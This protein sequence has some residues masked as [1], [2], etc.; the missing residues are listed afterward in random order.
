ME[1]HRVGRG[2]WVGRAGW[3][4]KVYA[5]GICGEDLEGGWRGVLEERGVWVRCRCGARVGV[6]GLGDEGMEC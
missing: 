5:N 3:R 4:E 1:G 6:E 2:R